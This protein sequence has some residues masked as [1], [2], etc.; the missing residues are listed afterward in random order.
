MPRPAPTAV[1][2]GPPSVAVLLR[3]LADGWAVTL[4]TLLALC[5]LVVGLR[6]LMDAVA[7]PLDAA[8]LGAV[9]LTA[10]TVAGA[11]R[12]STWW[13]RRPGRTVLRVMLPGLLLAL[14][15]ALTVPGT[16]IG[17]VVLLWLPL[18][19]EESWPAARR[20]FQ[21]PAR[22]AADNQPA[23]ANAS[24]TDDRGAEWQR[25]SRLTTP[26]GQELI[27]GWVSVDFAA[28]QRTAQAHLAFC[29]P[30]RG[31][32]EMHL[33]QIDGPAARI[34][35][36]QVLPFGVRLELKL[37]QPTEEPAQVVVQYSACEPGVDAAPQS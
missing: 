18:V 32:P 25:L 7:R 11:I 13:R 20:W 29:P 6:R 19:L 9:G 27:E 37:D 22:Q 34:K 2:A 36:A 8:I 10:A 14:S 26:H 5:T 28:G 23:S 24:A 33:E 16:S 30:L 12:A 3:T 21:R 4:L 31:T 15:L 1:D 35:A 17:G